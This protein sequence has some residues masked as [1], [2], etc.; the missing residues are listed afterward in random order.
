MG[1]TLDA[2][3]ER[4]SGCDGTPPVRTLLNLARQLR[5]NMETWAASPPNSSI[6]NEVISKAMR[7][8]AHLNA[9]PGSGPVAVPEGLEP[10]SRVPRS[11]RMQ[12]GRITAS[13]ATAS[14]IARLAESV[15]G[16][17]QARL[18]ISPGITLSRPDLVEWRPH[19]PGIWVRLLHR[20]ADGCCAALWRLDPG[21]RPLPHRHAAPELMMVLEGTLHLMNNELRAGDMCHADKGSIHDNIESRAGCVALIVGSENDEPLSSPTSG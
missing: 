8:A 15:S 14:A 21:A 2:S 13:R 18:G 17:P 3:I 9:S 7:L 16:W 1:Q 20:D 11:S 4:L 5:M 12:I 19:G 10:L 6:E